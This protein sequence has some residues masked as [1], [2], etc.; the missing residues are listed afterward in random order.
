MG[1]S[2]RIITLEL[3]TRYIDDY[4]NNDVYFNIDYKEQNLDRAR[5]WLSFLEDVEEK[6][7]EINAYIHKQYKE[8]CQ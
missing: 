8:K 7:D 1:E 5:K 4:L 2:I 6:M 3:S